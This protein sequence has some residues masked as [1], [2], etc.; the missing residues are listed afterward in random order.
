MLSDDHL[1]YIR[2]SSFH[3]N[4]SDQKDITAINQDLDFDVNSKNINSSKDK[5]AED[6]FDL[7]PNLSF[8]D[9][10]LSMNDDLK[11]DT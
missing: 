10:I 11:L 4:K 1:E 7:N 9:K 8:A 2:E 3:I 6:D 5:I